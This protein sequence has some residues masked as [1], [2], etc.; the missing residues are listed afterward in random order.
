MANYTTAACPDFFETDVILFLYTL[1]SQIPRRWVAAHVCVL[2]HLR[3]CDVR[4]E[5]RAK[6]HL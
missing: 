5:V 6:G 1:M 3:T 2:S 4:A